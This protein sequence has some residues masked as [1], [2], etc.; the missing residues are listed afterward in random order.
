MLYSQTEHGK[1]I[2]NE[3]WY[4]TI[5]GDV[6]HALGDKYSD[7]GDYKKAL[8]HHELHL[9]IAKDVEDKGK[10][11]HAYGHLGVIHYYLGDLKKAEEY[12]QQCLSIA[13]DVGD[14]G[15][16]GPPYVNLGNVHYTLGNLEKAKEYTQQGLS[17]AKDVGDQRT[18]GFAYHTLGEIHH[19]LRKF[20]MA[21]EYYQQFV[22]IAKA[23]GDQ[24]EQG[25]AYEFLGGVHFS[26]GDL[27]KAIELKQQGLS[28]AKEVG[29]K[30]NQARAYC[31]LG[32]VYKRQGDLNTALEYYQQFLSISKDSGHKI[33]QALAYFNLG[34]LYIAI[35]DL[36]KAEDCLKSSVDLYDNIRDLLHSRDDWKISLRN[37]HRNAYKALWAIQLKRN[38]IVEALSSAERGRAQALMDLLQSKYG[39]ELAQSSWSAENTEACCDILR[40]LPSQTVF[41]AIRKSSIH[42]WVLEKG[43]E[44]HFANTTLD[45]NTFQEE[46][47]IFV[48]SWIEKVCTKLRS[49]KCENRCLDG[50][51]DDE[52]PVQRSQ[53][54]ASVD[55]K[56][57]ALKELYNKFIDPIAALLHGDEIT[58]VP[59]GPLAFVPFSALID[60]HSRYL[61]ETLR[62]RLIPSLTSLKLTAECPEG[63]HSKT[64]A[65]LVGDP[66]VAVQIIIN[67]KCTDLPPLPRAKEEVKMIGAILNSRPLTGKSATKA[68]VLSR[69]NSVALVHIAAHGLPG[70]GEIILSPDPASKPGDF[71][72]TMKDILDSN[73]RARLV[74][75]SCCHTGRG[76]VKAE[77]VVGIARAFLG[78]GARSV[79]VTL[80]A[81]DDK[82]TKEFM[83]HFYKHLSEGQ[84]VSK[85]LHQ[86]RKHLRESHDFNDVGCWAPFV[87]IGDDVTINFNEIR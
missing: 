55:G 56:K 52:V 57:E 72:L 4:K 77:G 67:G 22:S 30:K 47:T 8:K 34:Q 5:K 29:N 66:R 62:I 84:C 41:L 27:K 78:A 50:L 76:E 28:I 69:I 18:Q 38:K 59:D 44:I 63:Y 83:K 53:Q 20:K 19:T 73:L 9:S 6:S 86:A 2:T 10:Q 25:E 60:Q 49:V 68:A 74:V 26:L 80:W 61:S 23:S 31:N 1:E 36:S 13:K 81:I 82:A 37:E 24:E 7:V 40:Y 15:R 39:I 54:T 45:G 11:E 21:M 12:H 17:I 64:G 70:T 85:C 75:L 33:R 35:G 14:K 79:V 65:L 48:Q 51:P 42:F 32:N 71:L 58:I 16:Q 43:K 87:L 46:G 3:R